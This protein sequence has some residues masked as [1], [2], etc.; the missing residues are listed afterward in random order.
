MVGDVPWAVP[1][2]PEGCR[3]IEAYRLMIERNADLVC[4]R[5]ADGALLDVL[6]PRDLWGFG[7]TPQMF[8]WLWMPVMQFKAM[9]RESIRQQVRKSSPACC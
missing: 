3:T 6:S 7:K 2:V 9:L 1:S 4:V 8:R 5:G